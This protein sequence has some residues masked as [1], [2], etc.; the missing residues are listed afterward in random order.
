MENLLHMSEFGSPLKVVFGSVAMMKR[1]SFKFN[2]CDR[3]KMSVINYYFCNCLI[4]FADT[5]EF[6]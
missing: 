6:R 5:K 3:K 4:L 1:T 2:N